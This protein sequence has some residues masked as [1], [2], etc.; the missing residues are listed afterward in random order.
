MSRH[1]KDGSQELTSEKFRLRLEELTQQYSVSE[2]SQDDA[3]SDPTDVYVSPTMGMQVT[4]GTS[5]RVVG[6]YELATGSSMQTSQALQGL[7]AAW[8]AH[9]LDAPAAILVQIDR[10]AEKM[11]AQLRWEKKLSG[12]ICG[13]RS[14]RNEMDSNQ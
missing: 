3:G 12:A 11:Q 10:Q 2:T 8:T 5:T 14:G 6:R 1:Q 4:S 7:E 13:R 9:A